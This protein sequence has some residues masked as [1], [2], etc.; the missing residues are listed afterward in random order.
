MLAP[1]R[2]RAAGAIVYDSIVIKR[3]HHAQI[4]VP[5]GAEAQARAFYCQLLGLPEIEKPAALAARGGFWLQ[6]GEEQLHV[7]VDRAGVDDGA[8]RAARREHVAYEVDDLDRWRARLSAAGVAVRDGEA[9][10]GYRRFEL[11]DP[12]GNRIELLARVE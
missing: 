5:V 8:A 6:V 2:S 10:P 3:I 12:F 9:I 4:M 7:G 11:R 1:Y